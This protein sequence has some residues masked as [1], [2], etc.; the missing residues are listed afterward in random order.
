ML[1]EKTSWLVCS[2]AK[3]DKVLPW[4]VCR[5]ALFFPTRADIMESQ[6]DCEILAPIA[7]SVFRSEFRD[8]TK[9][10]AA[11]LADIDGNRSMKKVKKKEQEASLGV[12]ASNSISER[13][14]PSSTLGFK[15]TIRADYTAAE[16]QT[17]SNN[18]V[19]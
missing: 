5:A 13:L 9:A 7:A 12:E 1:E 14:Y 4:D 19:G 11:Y 8:T 2:R 17:W 15:Y 3:K 10:T 18:G 6:D 16:G